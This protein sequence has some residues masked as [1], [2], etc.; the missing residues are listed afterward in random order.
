MIGKRVVICLPPKHKLSNY[1]DKKGIACDRVKMKEGMFYD[2]KVDEKVIRVE[3]RY[4][5]TSPEVFSDII[6]DDTE[7][8]IGDKV[9][10]NVN[11]NTLS[12]TVH[13]AFLEERDTG[14]DKIFSLLGMNVITKDSL[15]SHYYGKSYVTGIWPEYDFKN[16]KQAKK[17]INALFILSRIPDLCKGKKSNELI[18]LVEEFRKDYKVSSKTSKTTSSSCV[19][20]MKI[21]LK[22]KQKKKYLI[23]IDGET[24]IN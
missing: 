21:T 7:L 23:N 1:N 12:Y 24:I 4:I 22:P 9:C 6:D 13:E 2:V 5:D 19:R 14:N 10:F 8:A 11:D 17:L 3:S 18:E 16:F 15:A 20:S